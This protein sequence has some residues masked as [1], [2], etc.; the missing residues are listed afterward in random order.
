MQFLLLR[1]W[2]QCWYLLS[3]KSLQLQLL[4]SLSLEENG[5]VFVTLLSS[6][7][8]HRV[9][10]RSKRDF[11]DYCRRA[12][13]VSVSHEEMPIEDKACI[14][15]ESNSI[16]QVGKSQMG[17]FCRVPSLIF[18]GKGKTMSKTC[19][20]GVLIPSPQLKFQVLEKIYS[21]HMKM[22]AVFCIT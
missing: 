22:M 17:I 2:Q 12:D 19:I 21:I 3:V 16:H 1:G 8:C 11:E 5:M 9:D 15:D 14:Q 13:K 4:Y 6:L 7:S 20:V 10:K 18:P